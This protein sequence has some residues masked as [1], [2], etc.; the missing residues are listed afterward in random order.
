MGGSAKNEKQRIEKDA[1]GEV[2]VP[3]EH[4]WGAQTERSRLNFVIGVE[5][6]RW[7]R[8]VVRAFGLLKKCAALANLE[9]NQLPKEKVDLIVRAAQDV[10][11]AKLDD[12]FPLVVFQTGSG[13]QSNMN[14]NEVIANRAIQIA[15]GVVGSKK[16]IHPNDDV[17]HS[18]SSNDVFPT[19][20]HVA[21]LGQIR[22][23]LLPAVAQLRDTLDAKAKA[24]SDVVM[25]GRTHM[26][27]ATPLTL[28]QA[29]SGWAAQ[30][31]H[32]IV[33]IKRAC[34]GLM[35]L[36]IGGTAVGTGLNADPRFGETVA[37]KLAEATG[38]PF[39]S[40]RNKFAALSADDAMVN[41]SA[42]L[43]SLAGACMKI[44][45]D[46]RL[47]ASGPRAGIGEL[48]IPE[49]EPGSSIMP[50]KINPT[51]CEALTMVAVQVFGNDQA[52]AFAGSQGHFQLN[53]YRPVAL[54][55]VLESIQLLAEGCRSFDEH[56][57]RGIE[58]NVKRIKDNLDHSLMLVTAL[59]PH[60]G[61]EKAAQIALKAYREDTSLKE[62]AL[63]LGFVSADEFDAWVRPEDMTHPLKPQKK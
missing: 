34:E 32:A 4:L 9:L 27:D 28:G 7:G 39:T 31:D 11:D 29:I 24:F 38:E 51:Q 55:N 61:Y 10:I 40:A 8:P 37:R 56:C 57:A 12:E 58:P 60:I 35:P 1:L 18:Q 44:A 14:A 46:I 2:R 22:A 45:N 43:R 20:M 16:P 54:H 6:H 19:V 15:G 33:T 26:Q 30:L 5:R 53:V 41:V 50:G 42:A 48:K 23:A 17:N 52:V 49:N 13:T 62:A 3:G 47:Y 59:N 36:A 63:A 25:V 21:A